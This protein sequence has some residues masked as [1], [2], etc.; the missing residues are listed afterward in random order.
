MNVVRL[1]LLR[2]I[3]YASYAHKVWL[4]L[5]DRFD[6]VNGSRVFHLHTEIHTL[7]QGTLSV[8]DYFTRLRD[9]WDKFDAMMPCPGCPYS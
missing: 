4:D 1:G 5:K 9:L 6:K 8:T 3:V 2:C 7:M